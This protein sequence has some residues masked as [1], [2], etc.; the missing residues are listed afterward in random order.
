MGY[1]L[2][3]YMEHTTVDPQIPFNEKMF[4][5]FRMQP[6]Y[7]KTGQTTHKGDKHI[8]GSSVRKESHDQP[9]RL[10]LYGAS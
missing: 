8:Q 4:L 5:I 7:K 10:A 6:T 9:V 3:L 2:V 1:E